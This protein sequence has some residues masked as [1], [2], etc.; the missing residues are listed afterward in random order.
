MSL[1]VTLTGFLSFARKT[2]LDETVEDTTVF[3]SPFLLQTLVYRTLSAL[4][5]ALGTGDE[6]T[7]IPGF[8]SPDPS[9]VTLVFSYGQPADLSEFP[10]P[11]ITEVADALKAA[12]KKTETGLELFIPRTNDALV[13]ALADR[14]PVQ[15]P[16]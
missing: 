13:A 6:L 11:H 14:Q 2:H 9:G 8:S 5:R 7:L 16:S 10:D 4:Y 3:T 15:K 12:F 1:A